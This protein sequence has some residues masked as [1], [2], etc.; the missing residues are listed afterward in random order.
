MKTL[1]ALL[2]IPLSLAVV[3]LVGC[4]IQPTPPDPMQQPLHR[5]DY[6]QPSTNVEAV[7]ILPR[8]KVTLVNV[9]N[10][11]L[12]YGNKRGVYLIHDNKTGR[13]F[14]GISGIGISELSTHEEVSVSVDAEGNVETDSET[15][16]HEQ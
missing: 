4:D 12:A 2:T 13:E 7:K 10:D 3:A 15:V 6:S 8:V 5:A 1:H 9:I 16:V 11:E 14:I